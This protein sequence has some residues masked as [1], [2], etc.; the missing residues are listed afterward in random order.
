MTP[1]VVHCD[2]GT[3]GGKGSGAITVLGARLA[4]GVWVSA[5]RLLLKLSK[6]KMGQRAS[7]TCD[8]HGFPVTCPRRCPIN[9]D[10]KTVN[11]DCKG[12]GRFTRKVGPFVKTEGES[13]V[14]P[15]FGASVPKNVCVSEM[16]LD[17]QVL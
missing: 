3:E 14:F 12:K 2:T 15:T 16:L 1:R 17:T 7:A 13:P 4:L 10:E 8:A 5:P 9:S 6:E 11:P